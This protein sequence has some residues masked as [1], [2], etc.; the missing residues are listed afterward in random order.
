MRIHR[1]ALACVAALGLTNAASAARTQSIPEPLAAARPEITHDV[2]AWPARHRS[3]RPAPGA[4]APRDTA[5]DRTQVASSDRSRPGP[6][7][8]STTSDSTTANPDGDPAPVPS[9]PS[10]SA[11]PPPRARAAARCE[12][13]P[14][15][16][17]VQSV[18]AAGELM[19]ASG[20]AIKLLDIRLPA[21]EAV[22]AK[23]LAWLRAL[24]GQR[25]GVA[26]VG[27]ADRWGRI[28]AEVAA[29]GE[30]AAIDVADLLI[31][32]GFAMVDAGERDALC[33]PELLAREAQARGRRIG[34]W[35][36]ARFR[37]VGAGDMARLGALVGQF[38]LVEGR[39]RGVG[40]RRERTYLNFGSDWKSDFTITIPKRI[41]A[42]LRERG[43]TAASLKGARVRARGVLEEWQGVA[44]EITAA[45]MLE[46]P[47]EDLQRPPGPRP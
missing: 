5:S 7:Q 36:E 27:G 6:R 19:L 24:A 18:S 10:P 39:V 37:P 41:W 17:T 21:D 28:A 22:L 8:N 13:T 35:A 14:A 47:A 2:A 25:V 9:P 42:A 33:R 26:A 44:L 4:N 29:Q 45:D 11:A 12:R 15:D 46:V 38:A 3:A 30:G 40:E 20:R 23:P 16:D 31:S 34:L 43:V 1:A 32:E